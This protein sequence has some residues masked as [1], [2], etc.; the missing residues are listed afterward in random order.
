MFEVASTGQVAFSSTTAANGTK[1]AGVGRAGA[2][3]VKATNGSTGNGH[4]QAQHFIGSGNPPTCTAGATAQVGT[5][6]SCSVS[7]N[8]SFGEVTLTTGTGGL[9]P[10]LLFT[11]NFNAAYSAAPACTYSASNDN[12]ALYLSGTSGG[13]AIYLTTTTAGVSFTNVET[14][15]TAASAAHKFMYH[16]GGK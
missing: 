5:G 16:C 13:G 2:G 4:F 7:G 11:V 6:G 10:G 1:D 12:A 3:V 9:T 14:Q 15:L 8:D